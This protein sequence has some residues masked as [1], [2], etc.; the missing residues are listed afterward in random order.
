MEVTPGM[1]ERAGL[2]LPVVEPS[3]RGSLVVVAFGTVFGPVTCALTS[4][5]S[6]HTA[7]GFLAILLTAAAKTTMPMYSI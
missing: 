3:R 6:D 1:A 5:P 2:Q 7:L 4:I